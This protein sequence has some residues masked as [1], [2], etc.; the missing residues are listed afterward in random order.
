M[1]VERKAPSVPVSNDAR[2]ESRYQPGRIVKYKHLES[3]RLEEVLEL[4]PQVLELAR[5]HIGQNRIGVL[6]TSTQW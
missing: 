4:L 2:E 6:C 3:T 5:V 1:S